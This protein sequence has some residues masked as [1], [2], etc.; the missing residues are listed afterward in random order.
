MA[1]LV[2]LQKETLQPSALRAHL[3]G[4]ELGAIVEFNGVVRRTE[5]GQALRGINYEIYG[6]MA[7]KTLHTLLKEAHARW[8]EF[9]AVVAHVATGHRQEAFEICRWLID[10]LKERVPIWKREHLPLDPARET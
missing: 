5:K 7:E 4:E 8:G 1:D 9:E 10:E 3:Q 2:L 6:P